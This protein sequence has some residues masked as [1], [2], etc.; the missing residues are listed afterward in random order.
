MIELIVFLG[1]PGPQYARNRHNIAWLFAEKLSFLQNAP[2][3]RRFQGLFAPLR[4]PEPS[5]AELPALYGLAPHTFMN[6]S[7]KSVRE[8]AS[9]YKIPAEKIL[10]V[11]DELELPQGT[12][13]FK[14]GGGLGG[15]KGLRSMRDSFGTIEFWRLRI[16]IG[17]PNH[18]DISSYVLSNL[19]EDELILLDQISPKVEEALL[20][21]LRF[22]PQKLLPDWGKKNLDSEKKVD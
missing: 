10:I 17:R 11:H 18:P 2:W 4:L 22:G 16:G 6:L 20:K 3:K 14:F 19:S 13:S 15:H 5:P 7:G 8:A 1:N 9:F 12:V 21:S